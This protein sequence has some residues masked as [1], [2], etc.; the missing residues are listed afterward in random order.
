MWRF[1]AFKLLACWTIG[2]RSMAH[3]PSMDGVFLVHPTVDA[4]SKEETIAKNFR[5][6]KMSPCVCLGSRRPQKANAQVN[7]QKCGAFLSVLNLQLG[8]WQMR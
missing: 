2:V 5:F 1:D 4:I 6:K 3:F 8:W 7:R